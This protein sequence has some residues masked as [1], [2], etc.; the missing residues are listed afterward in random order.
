V[1][2]GAGAFV[3]IVGPVVAVAVVRPL[4]LGALLL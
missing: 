2:R 4:E 1:V 3:S